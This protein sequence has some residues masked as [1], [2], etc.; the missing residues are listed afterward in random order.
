MTL[1]EIQAPPKHLRFRMIKTA[2]LKDIV[3]KLKPKGAGHDGLEPSL[4]K[5][6]LPAI[7]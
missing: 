5:K 1:P 6:C 7:M 4:L 2:A 3:T